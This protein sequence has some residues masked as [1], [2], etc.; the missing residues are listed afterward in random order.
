MDLAVQKREK[1]GKANRALR[2][3]GLVPA[4][5]YG[6]G[7]ENKHL[8]VNGRD[9]LK[10][11]REAGENTIVNLVIGELKEP[12]LIYDVVKDPLTEEVIHVD[13]YKVRMD[14]EIRAHIPLRFVGESLA[15]KERL[16]TLN[17]AMGE[18]EVEAL[19]GNL[20]HDIEVDLSNLVDL[21]KSIHVRDLKVPEKVKVLLEPETVVATVV[22]LREEEVKEK[23]ADVSEV[24]VEGEEK[25]VERAAEKEEAEKVGEEK[26]EKR[27]EA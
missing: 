19:P 12:A 23:P 24:K 21:N 4:E 16:G 7:V 8:S 20:P 9:F 26:S 6:R 3:K 5:F 13:F 17:K 2:Q 18:V 27:R 1:F 25:K 22:P 15:V 10:V 11:F 14:E